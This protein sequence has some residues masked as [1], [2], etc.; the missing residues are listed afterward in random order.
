MAAKPIAHLT[1][2]LLEE[3]GTIK[4]NRFSQCL[5]PSWLL[6]TLFLTMVLLLYTILRLIEKV[7]KFVYIFSDNT[8][9]F[10]KEVDEVY[11]T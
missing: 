11:N 3:D 1:G 10:L 4:S 7:Y 2:S 9:L 5:T 6:L 8:S